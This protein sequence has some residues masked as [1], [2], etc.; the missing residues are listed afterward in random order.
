MQSEKVMI[1]K[2][3]MPILIFILFSTIII[4]ILI[5]RKPNNK[6]KDMII[7][8]REIVKPIKIKERKD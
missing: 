3:E 6:Q 7:I 2:L 1:K 8:E 4:Q 5:L